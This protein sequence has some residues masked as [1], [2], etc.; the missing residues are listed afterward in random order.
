MPSEDFGYP[1]R[2]HILGVHNIVL[3][4]WRGNEKEKIDS[5]IDINEYL[6]GWNS[7]TF[8]H[9]LNQSLTDTTIKNP[10]K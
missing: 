10:K 8:A 2:D 9:P 3:G 7:N 5:G 4:T 1:N 6:S